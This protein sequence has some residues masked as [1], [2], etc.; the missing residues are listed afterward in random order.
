VSAKRDQWDTAAAHRLRQ[1]VM[2]AVLRGR[3]YAPDQTYELSKASQ[4]API[5]AHIATILQRHADL[6]AADMR[7]SQAASI[8]V[9]EQ[10]T[11]NACIAEADAEVDRFL[12]GRKTRAA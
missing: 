4:V 2:R 1:H 8:D 9:D 7:E 5:S 12:E 3:D 6:W 10:R 11:W